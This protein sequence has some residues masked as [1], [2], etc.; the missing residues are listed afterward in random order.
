[1][2]NT[3]TFSPRRASGLARVWALLGLLLLLS[4]RL[5]AYDV[6]VAQDGTGD[7]T[8]VQ[9]AINAAPTN[10]TAVYSIFIKNGRYAEKMSVPSNKP[11]LQLV[12]ESVA[13][14]ILTYSDGASTSVGGN[15]LG[16]QGSA[17]FSIS[18]SDFS[19][20]NITFENTFGDGSQ[21]VA[22]LVNA[23][24][25]V[26]KNCRFLGNQ[27]TLYVKGSGTPMHYF[28]DC[29]IDGNVDFIFGSSV[30][31]FE[32]CVVYAKSRTS[33]GASYITAA[34]TPAGQ[35]YG[36]VFRNTTL[37]SNTGG[38]LYY[39]GRPWQ[40]DAANAAAPT[41]NKTVFLKSRVGINQLQPAGWVTWDAGTN[42]S[43]ITYAEF[44]P[45][46]FNGNAVNVS[47]RAA[48]SRQ[49]AVADTAAYQRA[50]VFGSWN[51]CA[52]A[53]NVCATFSPDIAVAN[54]RA[55]KGASQTTINW[56]ISWAMTGIRYDLYR[57]S[58]NVTFSQINTVTA[59]NDS[60]WNF[61]M[62]DAL[63]VAGSAY[64]YYVRA[65]KAGLATHQTA[66]V[67]VSSVPTITANT[68]ALG[69][70]AQYQTGTSAVQT[71]TVSG[72]NLTAN[73][74][75][76][77]PAN[78]EVSANGGT[79]WATNVAPLVLTPAA[80]T[81][82]AT[83]ISVRLNAATAGTYAGNI[84][85]SSPGAT[86]LNVAVTGAKTNTAAQVSNVLQWWSLK[87]S[88]Q[89]SAQVRSAAV[90][91]STSTFNQLVPSN[92][93][94]V[95]A[96]P[97]RSSR[98]GQAFA[99]TATGQWTT[100]VGGPGSSLN[101]RFYKQFTVTA[102]AASAV[103]IDSLVFWN[104]IYNTT[105]LAG[106]SYSLTGF[107]VGNA[108]SVNVTNGVGPLGTLTTGGGTNGAPASFAIR[109]QNSGTNQTYRL[110]LNGTTGVTVPA[111]QT[112]TI[113]MY[114]T[115]SSTSN[116]R[117]MLLRDVMVK[118][119]ALSAPCN[120]A[121]SY[122]NATYCASGTNPTPTVTGTA[123]G[124]FTSTTGL[125][126][127]GSTGTINLA[128]STP[129][130]YVITYTPGVACS[131]TAT[132]TVTAAT[133]AAF[134][135]PAATY[136]TSQSSTVPV[137]LGTGGTAGTF[138][139]SVAGLTL[140]ATTG[141]ITPGSSTPGTYTVTNAVAA[142]GGCAAASATFSV[143]ITAAPA[144]TF[145]Y[146][147]AAY[148]ASSNLVTP[149]VATGSTAGTYSSTT[150]LSIDPTTGAVNLGSSTPGTYV[151]TNSLAAS[152]ACAAIA[153]TFSLTINPI[154][155]Q[156]TVT[157]QS[158]GGATTLTSSATSGNQWYLGTT[159]V[160]GATSQTYVV[161]TPAQLGSY[162][163]V[164]TSAAGCVSAPSA[165]IVVTSRRAALA[166]SS[167]RVYP[168]PAQGHLTVE[169]AGYRQATELSLLNALGQV[170][171]TRML[172][173]NESVAPQQFSLVGLAAGVYVLRATTAGGLDTRRVV[174][175]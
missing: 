84:V 120:A 144:A 59:A 55:A 105:G 31:V 38:T 93:T 143:T 72:E 141:T 62:T 42:T 76:T 44:R 29:Y 98:Y 63:P 134:T 139:A 79:N 130:T 56:N 154:P 137:T 58:D 87:V 35:A 48:W 16:T 4:T 10:R 27:D 40:N 129:G 153:A 126:I 7:F 34:N 136:C 112:L 173:A 150:G 163:V 118:G 50:T 51:P 106:V 158:S 36:F 116:G 61:Q 11:F 92:G 138:S 32:N 147:N 110:A 17:S 67:Q 8:T 156:P 113:R 117:Y 157:V 70:F 159:A 107:A 100:A 47:Q 73:V 69:T 5:Y 80:N 175:R 164:T 127:E 91:A 41:N 81:L 66:T 151:I 85:H 160:P 28:R 71:Y 104:A 171:L 26:F 167:L 78:Y 21:A 133:S 102:D 148:C 95:T 108:D 1:M 19:A 83:I 122:A 125:S 60:T 169:L 15:T 123:G 142:S 166:G 86:A 75:I 132:V 121:F 101:R 149:T 174:V 18:A 24:R 64:Y 89:D 145:S 12:G 161:N 6:T 119:E 140:D 128:T 172:T 96:Y 57:S 46:H 90:T 74:T 30:A 103:R 33:N 14:T 165:A 20:F 88:D 54:F 23:D 111:G 3:P 43:L 39:L 162:T 114:F 25:A 135:Y 146:A 49:L 124:A 152:G 53:S 52:V 65:S 131:S 170:V 168:N 82:A 109:N 99:P 155:A 115:T 97:A 45:R 9:A 94:T 68:V 13:N 2:V 77:P 22:V 37:P